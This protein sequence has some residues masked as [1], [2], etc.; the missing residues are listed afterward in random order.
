MKAVVLY[1]SKTG[2]TKKIA[3]TIME[4]LKEADVEVK[5]QGIDGT[6][7]L[8]WF[9]YDLI[10]LGF[11][12]HQWHPP[13]EVV[14][15]LQARSKIYRNKDMLK[16]GAPKIP[17]KYTL[18]FCTYSG[19]HT[20][21]DEAIPAGKYAGQFFAHL[22]FSVEECYIIGEFHGSEEKSTRG[23]L[24]DIRGRPNEDDL[25]KVKNQVFNLISKL[26]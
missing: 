9:D 7:D 8:D 16:I 21:I 25:A 19:P 15:Y 6:V 10:C 3:Q 18:I 17:G 24:G 12:S 22:G 20:G 1:W 14:N 2:N 5:L 4:A 13:E 26:K 23:P 11:P